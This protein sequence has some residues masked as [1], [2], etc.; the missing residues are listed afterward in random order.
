[1]HLGY[2]LQWFSFAGIVALVAL[3]LRWS[4]RRRTTLMMETGKP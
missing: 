2:A 3:R 4:G 1:M